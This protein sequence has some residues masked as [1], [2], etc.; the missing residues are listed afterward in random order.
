V[1]DERW[2]LPLD[3]DADE[4]VLA[5]PERRGAAA[6]AHVLARISRVVEDV[7]PSGEIFDVLVLALYAVWGL[8]AAVCTPLYLALSWG[9]PRPPNWWGLVATF[10]VFE[11]GL[12]A[13]LW[14]AL[15]RA[16]GAVGVMLFGLLV[17]VPGI[18]VAFTARAILRED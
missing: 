8:L 7:Q 2:E 18:G 11:L 10:W 17:L 3:E 15:T 16:E 14:L 5:R 13:A 12:V 6:L 9:Q 4:P 1:E